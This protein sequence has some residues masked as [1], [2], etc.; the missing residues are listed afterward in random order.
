M[1]IGKSIRQIRTENNMSQEDFAAI[2]FVTRQ[3]I[4]NWENEKSYPD[5]NT[6]VKISDRFGVS[7]DKLL[8]EDEKM[9]NEISEKTA[10]G[11]KWNR[12]RRTV[13]IVISVMIICFMITLAVYGTVWV[14]RKNSLEKKFS[15]GINSLGFSESNERYYILRKNN[16]TY[17][18]P[19]Q[20]MPSFW[21]FST[22]FHAKFLDCSY[23]E[24]EYTF[25]VRFSGEIR[26]LTVT[27]G[28]GEDYYS[29]IDGSELPENICKAYNREMI[30]KIL[31]YGQNIYNQVY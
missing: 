8:K 24:N 10:T 5:L 16:I 23:Q 9:V 29:S 19:H 30:E 12:I 26:S 31:D 17:V 6:I 13:F 28:N 18:L 22:D 27:D 4:S 7:L 20:E 21:D 25:N 2:F 1:N 11:I 14:S 15:Q 3:T